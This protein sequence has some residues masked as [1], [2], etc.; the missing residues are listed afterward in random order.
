[1]DALHTQRRNE[2]DNILRA[3]ED[4][5]VTDSCVAIVPAEEGIVRTKSQGDGMPAPEGVGHDLARACCG[6]EERRDRL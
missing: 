2:Y 4:T 5:L 3:T 1:M 6:D